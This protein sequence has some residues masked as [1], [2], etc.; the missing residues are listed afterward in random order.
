M[1]E[2]TCWVCTG[3]LGDV[4][5]LLPACK[6]EHDAGNRVALMVSK[7]FAPV[8]DG[9]SY[10][11][12]VVFNDDWQQLEKAAKLA[13][14]EYRK[15][16]VCQV[17]GPKEET[18]KAYLAAGMKFGDSMTESFCKD[19]WRIAG[20]FPS[21]KDNHPL[22]FDRRDPKREAELLKSFHPVSSR[23][24]VILFYGGGLTSPYPYKDLLW[25]YLNARIHKRQ[26]QFIDLGGV[27]AER[28]YDLL[29]VYELADIL[30][31]VDSAPL[32]LAQA[33][34]KLAVIALTQD[35]PTLWHG[36]P[37]RNNR[38]MTIRYSDIGRITEIPD[39]ITDHFKRGGRFMP[40]KASKGVHVYSLYQLASRELHTIARRNW[41]RHVYGAVDWISCPI[42]PRTFGRDTTTVFGQ[43]RQFPFVKDVIRS[44]AQLC[45]MDDTIILTRA[46]TC[47]RP[48]TVKT[49]K[50]PV[51]GARCIVT[52]ARRYVDDPGVP[53]YEN[54]LFAFTK[55]WW[56]EHQDDYPDMVMGFD[57][58]W[59]RILCE[60]ILKHGGERREDLCFRKPGPAIPYQNDPYKN[61]NSMLAERWKEAN[62]IDDSLPDVTEQINCQR[63]NPVALFKHGYNPHIV[64]MGKGYL[65]AYRSH[66]WND[67]RTCIAI[68]RLDDSFN[69]TSNR[70]LEPETSGKSTEDPKLFYHR[71]AIHLSYVESE[72]PNNPNKARVCYGPLVFTGEEWTMP[73]RYKPQ[74]SYMQD[75]EKNW[76]FFS[77][78]EKLYCIYSSS[79]SFRA[80]ELNED[81]ILN[82]WEEPGLSWKWGPIRG[83]SA[84]VIYEGKCVRVFHS[85]TWINPPPTVWR[86][87]IGAM[88]CDLEPPHKPIRIAKMPIAGGSAH[89]HVWR[90]EGKP[91][92]HHKMN[93]IFP[94]SLW[95][96]GGGLCMSLGVND[97]ASYIVAFRTNT[98]SVLEQALHL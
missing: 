54:D 7:E 60:L 28:F 36:S 8:L 1:K 89:D 42:D 46:E 57:Q 65:M 98:G 61:H 73:T 95:A 75:L 62:G 25:E 12:P 74:P 51:C 82:S 16:K 52:A 32:H 38:V 55:A 71:G 50:G 93:V 22:I 47:M 18:N 13:A 91:C 10:V 40:V 78:N 35:K 68:A 53:Q 64:Q 41:R 29:G 43:G 44:A 4:L 90:E 17:A 63:I 86:Y 58:D 27:K 70:W 84:P 94:G 77:E 48:K 14:S 76:V 45:D 79:P 88:E 33:C 2:Q 69:V 24:V 85:T 34:P 97:D 26:C 56:V 59:G 81:Q 83:G 11:D 39:R 30:V 20:H 9:V 5:N 3:K 66:R 72:W 67:K 37:W 96:G 49:I 19:Q 87:W 23:Q 80:F 15:V 21:F 6:I 31:S 92:E